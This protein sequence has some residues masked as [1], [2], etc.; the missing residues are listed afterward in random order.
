MRISTF[1][2]QWFLRRISLYIHMK[3]AFP[4]CCPILSQGP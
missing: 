3:N 2:A 1:L 4:Y